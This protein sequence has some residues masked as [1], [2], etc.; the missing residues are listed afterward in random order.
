[1]RKL[2]AVASLCSTLLYQ[3]LKA[4]YYFYNNKY[5]ENPVVFEIGVAAGVM[6]SLTDL[7]G[8]KGIG[9]NFIKDLRWK[10]ARPSFGGYF[11]TNYLDKFTLRLEGTYGQVVGFDSILRDVAPTTS[12]RY[13]RNL[14]FKSTI[15]ELQV[16]VEVHPIMFRDFGNDD[17]PRL[18]HYVLLGLGYF[19]FD[20][21]AKLNDT[22]HSLQPL[23]LE[24]QGFKEYPNSKPY[25]LNQINLVGG[26][27]VKYEISSLLNARLEFVYRKLFTDYLDDA[28]A[29]SYIDPSLFYNYLTPNQAIIA[30]K[31]YERKSELT[32]GKPS[33]PIDQR[34]DSKDNDSYFTI[35]FKIGLVLG[36]QNR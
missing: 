10:T 21:K 28:S 2:F 24:G 32:P 17:P 30:H 26:L 1:M 14:S 18:S 11:L 20:P 12:G 3:P 23:R 36:R 15:S 7:G 19:S 13:E 27:G 25:K 6:N 9:K 35:Q 31:L 8:K 4:Q 16:A 34:G 33:K 5:L 22:W 29:D